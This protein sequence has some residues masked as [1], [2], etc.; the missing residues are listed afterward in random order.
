MKERE[1]GTEEQEEGK[2]GGARG[3]G[4]GASQEHQVPANGPVG[5]VRVGAGRA[6]YGRL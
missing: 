1:K 6:G 4:I 5:R 3:G 2:G